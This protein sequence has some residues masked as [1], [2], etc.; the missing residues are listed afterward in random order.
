MRIQ[1][2]PITSMSLMRATYS[3]QSLQPPYFQLRRRPKNKQTNSATSP[4]TG[5]SE[6]KNQKY[7]RAPNV[8]P[9]VHKSAP[10]DGPRKYRALRR[11]SG[12]SSSVKPQLPHFSFHASTSRLHEVHIRFILVQYSKTGRRRPVS[13]YVIKWVLEF[14]VANR[15]KVQVGSS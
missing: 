11:S 8:H 1:T 3:S 5:I 13:S 4:K 2:I 14:T 12:T 15:F 10:S 6:I 9:W 7:K